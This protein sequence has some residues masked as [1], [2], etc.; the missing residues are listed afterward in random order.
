MSLNRK[1]SAVTSQKLHCARAWVS[2][3]HGKCC[4]IR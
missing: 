1:N 4:N 3:K 2:E